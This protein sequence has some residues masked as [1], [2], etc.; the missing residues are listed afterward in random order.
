MKIALYDKEFAHLNSYCGY[1]AP[2]N[3]EWDRSGAYHHVSIFTERCFDQGAACTSPVRVAWLLEP[4]AIHP[5]GYEAFHRGE[6][7]WATHVLTFDD[8]IFERAKSFNIEPIFWT[9]G[10]SWI[11]RKDWLIYNKSNTVSILASAKNWTTGHRF[12]QE[13][14]DAV[15]DQ[16][17]LVAGYNRKP[18]EPKQAAY[19]DFRYTIAIENSKLDYYWTDKLLDPLLCGTIPIFWGCPNLC[20]Y[21]NM[22]GIFTFDTVDE[23]R[24]ILPTLGPD[25]YN[26]R[27]TAVIENFEIAQKFAIVEDYMYETFFRQI[28]QED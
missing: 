17:D 2:A 20:T 5:Y 25:D 15:G 14:I 26:S 23:L 11:W 12:R 4:E 27:I 28:D 13:V 21:F 24:A 1:D 18:I 19:Q 6:C 10:G 9:P 7:A 8:R 3:I 22:A 16:L